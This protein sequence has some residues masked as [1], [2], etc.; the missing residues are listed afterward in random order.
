MGGSGDHETI[1]VDNG[2]LS[3]IRIGNPDAHSHTFT[4]LLSTPVE[5]AADDT[6]ICPK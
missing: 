6:L 2:S 1:A 3:K 5:L 4:W